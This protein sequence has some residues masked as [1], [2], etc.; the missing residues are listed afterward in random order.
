MFTRFLLLF[1]LLILP[2]IKCK[3]NI[4][5][6]FTKIWKYEPSEGV[7]SPNWNN[8]PIN[9]TVD[10]FYLSKVNSTH[11]SKFFEVNLENVTEMYLPIDKYEGMKY[12]C[13]S[14]NTDLPNTKMD[15]FTLRQILLHSPQKEEF[16][17]TFIQI[18]YK[19]IKYEKLP[20]EGHVLTIEDFLLIDTE[21][22]IEY[23][24]PATPFI[25]NGIL[26]G[27]KIVINI[28]PRETD[29]IKIGSYSFNNPLHF[30]SIL[31]I[32]VG[33]LCFILFICMI[34][35]LICSC[36]QRTEKNK[37]LRMASMT[38]E[39]DMIIKGMNEINKEE[40]DDTS[41]GT[42]IEI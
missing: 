42:D 39:R 38:I 26:D 5:I 27:N 30:M 15:N 34:I 25:K 14:K 18:K 13:L 19:N 35:V 8:H 37:K 4:T 17:Y 1:F 6:C 10:V 12:P 7:E 24:I 3:I 16:A 20:F 22:G 41:T 2:Y 36:T 28:K 11:F 40:E 21:L 33:V 32:S 31:S 9:T 29:I 23:V